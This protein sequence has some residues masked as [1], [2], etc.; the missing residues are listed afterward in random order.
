ML[1]Y[2]CISKCTEEYTPHQFKTVLNWSRRKS[3]KVLKE[4]PDVKYFTCDV[5]GKSLQVSNVH[6]LLVMHMEINL[7][8]HVSSNCMQTHASIMS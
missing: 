6:N 8:T 1:S 4:D 3:V 2:T 7:Y 5:C